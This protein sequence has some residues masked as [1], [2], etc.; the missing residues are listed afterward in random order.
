ME[1]LIKNPITIWLRWWLKVLF[2]KIK[3]SGRHI[4]LE[5]LCEIKQVQ[6]SEHNTIRKYARL[7]DVSIG[8]H[9]Y[10]GRESQVYH[11]QIGAFTCIGP[12]VIIGPGEHPTKD[13]VSSHPMFYS[14]LAQSNPVIVH[15][16]RFE[17]FSTTHIGNDVW[18]GARA[19]LKT[20]ITVGNGAI[21]AAGA[22]VAK[23]VEPYSIVGGIPAK[24]IRYRFTQEQI[25]HLQKTQW[26]NRDLNWL[27]EHK[28][29]FLHIQT[30]MDRVK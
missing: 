13:F 9:S 15:K 4:H 23:D 10:V 29:E 7:R 5:Y 21:I 22:V 24:H 2:H 11:A 28:D 1:F 6:F 18:I 25:T 16:N 12:E 19:I 26:W 30:F 27:I 3:F 14:T 17:E 20:G 8:K